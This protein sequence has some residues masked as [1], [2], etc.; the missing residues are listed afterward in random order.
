[1]KTPRTKKPQGGKFGLVSFADRLREKLRL[2]ENRMMS[3]H[4]ISTIEQRIQD[5]DGPLVIGGPSR[6]WGNTDAT[7]KKLQLEMKKTY[8]SWFEL[9]CMLF[10]QPTNEIREEIKETDAFVRRWIEKESDWE[11]PETIEEAK[12]VF[13]EKIRAF[14]D[15]IDV[16]SSGVKTGEYIL[17]PD[18]NA[19]IAAP[20]LSRYSEVIGSDKFRVVVLPTIMSELETLK[21]KNIDLGVREKVKSAIRYLKGLRNQGDPLIGVRIG[22]DITVCWEPREPDLANSLRWLKA[23]VADDHIV[24]GVIEIQRDNPDALVVLVTSDV[25]LQNKAVLAGISFTEPPEDLK[26]RKLRKKETVRVEATGRV[27]LD[28]PSTSH[29]R[30]RICVTIHNDDPDTITVKSIGLAFKGGKKIEMRTVGTQSVPLRIE[31]RDFTRHP[32]LCVVPYTET[33]ELPK[34]NKVYATTSHEPNKLYYGKIEDLADF[35]KRLHES[36]TASD[37]MTPEQIARH[38]EMVKNRGRRIRHPGTGFVNR[39]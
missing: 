33:E 3:L 6:S 28:F 8:S 10:G 27:D 5:S 15:L 30:E 19:L 1:M 4:H 34:I 21:F 36:R 26:E 25:G 23:H 39:W 22:K 7:Q 31:G 18:T 38:K 32:V 17:V 20:D 11:I 2:I 9:F 24:A 29:H 13:R 16:A 37:Y 12:E 35:V 14:D